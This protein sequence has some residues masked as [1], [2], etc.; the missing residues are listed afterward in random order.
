MCS[1]I[2]WN[3][4]PKFINNTLH[5]DFSPHLSTS[6]ILFTSTHRIEMAKEEG[7]YMLLTQLPILYLTLKQGLELMRE[8]GEPM[9]FRIFDFPMSFKGLSMR[10]VMGQ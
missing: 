2:L 1:H 4:V 9:E 3:E 10:G 7:T 8:S 5:P 6:Q